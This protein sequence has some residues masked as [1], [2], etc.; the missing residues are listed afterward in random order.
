M[1]LPN[2]QSSD[3]ASLAIFLVGLSQLQALCIISQQLGKFN[4]EVQ[5]RNTQFGSKFTIFVPCDFEI[6]GMTLNK[7]NLR[8]LI[9]ATSLV[10]LGH[11]F[12]T[13]S[14]FVHHLK[15]VNSNWSYSPE[16]LISGE[17]LQFFVPRDLQIL[18]MTL[19]KNR[20]PHLCCFKLCASFHSHQ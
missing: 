5:S 14:S 12:Y 2:L 3:I 18:W 20:T 4:L 7:A 9:A 6:W 8:D 10:I 15:S 1:G 11:I 16:T 13:I 17:N 19:K